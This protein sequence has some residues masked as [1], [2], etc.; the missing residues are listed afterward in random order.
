MATV[1]LEEKTIG[2]VTLYLPD[3][4]MTEWCAGQGISQRDKS[5]EG[6]G[7]VEYVGGHH[8]S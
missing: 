1:R 4:R 6:K 3:D 5:R 2:L 7:M 8:V